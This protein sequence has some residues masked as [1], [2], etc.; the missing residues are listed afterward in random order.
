MRTC[1]MAVAASGAAGRGTALPPGELLQQAVASLDSLQ[2][3]FACVGCRVHLHACN[4]RAP[5]SRGLWWGGSVPHY[6]VHC[7]P[8]RLHALTHVWVV[9]PD[10]ISGVHRSTQERQRRG[11]AVPVA[12][13]R[14]GD[15]SRTGMGHS[16]PGGAGCRPCWL[17]LPS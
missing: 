16:D 7:L 2:D 10:R 3:L 4:A 15:V 11:V 9:F 17:S 6:A 8:G 12:Q 14:V 5:I 13:G 1:A